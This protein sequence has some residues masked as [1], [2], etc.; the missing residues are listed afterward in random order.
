MK[1]YF[2]T[3]N[4]RNGDKAFNK[5]NYSEALQYYRKGL[6]AVIAALSNSESP[7]LLYEKAYVLKE[8]L[9]TSAILMGEMKGD[10]FKLLQQLEA[11][12]LDESNQFN[13]LVTTL[14]EAAKDDAQLAADIKSLQQ[15]FA[16]AQSALRMNAC[17]AYWN[18]YLYLIEP[19][20]SNQVEDALGIEQRLKQ[21]INI[22]DRCAQIYADSTAAEK[23]KIGGDNNHIIGELAKLHERLSD[24]FAECA[25]DQ[26]L[27]AT[28]KRDALINA[29]EHTKH[30]LRAVGKMTLV[31]QNVRVLLHLSY[32]NLK[33]HLF[34]Q[35]GNKQYLNEMRDHIRLHSL[36]EQEMSSSCKLE[37]YD[38][39]FLLAES[40][41]MALNWSCKIIEL[42][43][44]AISASLQQVVQKAKNFLLAAVPIPSP[45]A[46][47]PPFQAPFSV[48]P[49]LS[50]S[51]FSFW[52]TAPFPSALVPSGVVFNPLLQRAP[53]TVSQASFSLFNQP[54]AGDL[55][56]RAEM[57]H[58]EHDNVAEYQ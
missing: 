22:I 45:W 39:L 46:P 32:L 13:A 28:E 18:A 58:E 30:A 54:R 17:V 55:A 37:L 31:D 9:Y 5:K 6:S 11:S 25:E 2:S 7:A 38:Y 52:G 14:S 21:S 23:Q 8:I 50:L 16:E 4:Q 34:N 35:T 36:E 42:E 43:K 27:T 26:Q 1:A 47:I 10:D 48:V 49:V 3:P 41:Q 53:I 12:T 29:V 33:E 24:H 44:D 56:L 19:V 40:P 15:E 57:S 51:P 20:N